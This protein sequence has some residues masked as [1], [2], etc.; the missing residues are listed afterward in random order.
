MIKNHISQYSIAQDR[1]QIASNFTDF[2]FIEA[3][4]TINNLLGTCRIDWKKNNGENINYPKNLALNL[5]AR[6]GYLNQFLQDY[7]TIISADYSS[8]FLELIQ[9]DSIK[10]LMNEK[11]WCFTGN[12]F[13]LIINNLNLFDFNQLE[14]IFTFIF[15]SMKKEAIFLNSF[16]GEKS[17]CE[18]EKTIIDINSN[19]YQ[20]TNKPLR[21]FINFNEITDLLSMIGFKN[22]ALISEEIM[23]EYKDLNNFFQ[24]LKNMGEQNVI[25]NDYEAIDLG[26]IE[27]INQFY[28]KNSDN[29]YEVKIEIIG[30]SCVKC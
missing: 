8:N 24:D 30:V 25:F 14:K 10:I 18:L 15:H 11:N 3:S 1:N 9:D 6:N 21:K 12:Q 17:L 23:V 19:Q 13:D 16:W 26:L 2:L 5:G 22:I 20:K 4:E 28:P 7:K 29:K 27:M